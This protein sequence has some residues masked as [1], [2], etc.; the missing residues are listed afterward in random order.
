M[1]VG[2]PGDGHTGCEA[3][4]KAVLRQAGVEVSTDFVEVR[5]QTAEEQKILNIDRQT[6]N[7]SDWTSLQRKAA[8]AQPQNVS[9]AERAR[10]VNLVPHPTQHIGGGLGG[11][12]EWLYDC[13]WQL[14]Q[15]SA[16]RARHPTLLMLPGGRV[17]DGQSRVG[18]ALWTQTESS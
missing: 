5:G 12:D 3:V 7:L 16:H 13:R 11:H 1:S 8:C 2:V 6:K 9:P 4:H 17:V 15:N 14:A 10:R 18:D